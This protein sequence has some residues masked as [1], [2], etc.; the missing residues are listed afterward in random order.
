MILKFNEIYSEFKNKNIVNLD[1]YSAN[2][3]ELIKKLQIQIKDVTKRQQ[4]FILVIFA[5]MFQ[6]IMF[7]LIKG[8]TYT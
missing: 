4:N 3:I 1:T 2:I 8:Y 6:Y 5:L 7:E